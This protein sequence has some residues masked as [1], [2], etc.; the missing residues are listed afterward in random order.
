MN[1]FEILLPELWAL[2][3]AE[4]CPGWDSRPRVMLQ[5][6]CKAAAALDPGYIYAPVWV[7]FRKR[8][9]AYGKDTNLY[10]ADLKHIHEMFHVHELLDQPWFIPPTRTRLWSTHCDRWLVLFDWVLAPD[11]FIKL[12]YIG[13]ES[14]AWEWS[15]WTNDEGYNFECDE[16]VFV[17]KPTLGE[18][19]LEAP[20]LGMGVC[21]QLIRLWSKD[22][23]LQSLVLR[24]GARKDT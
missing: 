12:N 9:Q 11:I 2:I 5:R 3:R 6:T 21:P 15:L 16:E 22:A 13:R 17:S 23:D 24:K 19:L 18:I 7:D 10:W 4:L 20:T 8:A 1:P 14:N